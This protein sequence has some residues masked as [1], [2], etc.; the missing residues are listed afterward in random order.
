L[1]RT[2]KVGY[3]LGDGV[4]PEVV[5]AALRVVKEVADLDL[6]ELKAGYEYYKKTGKPFEE[7]F[8]SK[9]MEA[10]AILKGPLQTPY[11]PGTL[12]SIN[13]AIRQELDLYANVRPFRS[14]AGVSLSAFDFVIVR[15]NTED[16]YVGAEWKHGDVAFSVKVVSE[17]ASRR[18]SK[19]ALQYAVER[20]Y[21]KVAVVHKANIMKETDGLFRK[22]FFEE[23]SKYPQIETEEVLVDAA[24][25]RLVKSPGS[26]QVIVTLN[27]Y[28]D[29]LSDLAAGLV[30]SIGL[31]GSAQIGEK[32]A[33]FEP[34]H[35]TAPDIA[36]KG[37]ANPLGQIEA[38][39][40]MLEY[41]SA[42]H[43]DAALARAAKLIRA[44]VR[45]VVEERK[46]LPLDLGGTSTT[47][48]VAEAV[49]SSIRQLE[50]EA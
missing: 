12:R 36:G 24:A 10:D 47:F 27:M 29:I 41:L 1:P 17:K 25:Y 6:F 8:F 43:S 40:L 31:C 4:G 26:F 42:K 49:V 23:A 22:A 20:G 3:I 33:V 48:E 38:A 32:A 19:F 45:K 15:E 35:G 7:D 18:I 28:G 46:A 44:G 21:R 37:I 16:L 13:V 34:V 11:G 39:G 5:L 14:Y 50:S 2:Y 9:A 30:G